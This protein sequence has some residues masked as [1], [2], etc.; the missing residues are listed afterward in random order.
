MCGFS[1]ELSVKDRV[2]ACALANMTE[3][4]RHRGPDSGGLF[5][6]DRI[7]LG[8]RR[9][10]ILGLNAASHQPMIDP[11]LGLGIVFNGCIYNFRELK[12]DLER[13]GFRFFRMATPKS[14]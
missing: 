9:L 13:Q 14:S 4:L 10:A 1:G 11:E 5:I 3:A 2:D 8:H 6:E 7:G 12:Q